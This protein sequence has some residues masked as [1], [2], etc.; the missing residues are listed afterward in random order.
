MGTHNIKLPNNTPII[1]KE[2]P[3]PAA[4][5][6]R[7]FL[8]DHRHREILVQ[9]FNKDEISMVKAGLF[10]KWIPEHQVP[11]FRDSG[12]QVIPVQLVGVPHEE[13]ATMAIQI[14]Q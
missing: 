14:V 12:Y 7:T 2:G 1:K 11:V 9:V 5:Q 8:I 6:E 3:P 13:T 4:K 10:Y